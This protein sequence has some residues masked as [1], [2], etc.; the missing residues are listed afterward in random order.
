MNFSGKFY[1]EEV[2]ENVITK[3]FLFTLLFLCDS[4]FH[5]EIFREDCLREIF[6]VVGIVYFF[7]GGGGDFPLDLWAAMGKFP[8]IL[9]G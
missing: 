4:I 2:C 7:H 5:V 9:R 8:K 6:S 3:F 1:N